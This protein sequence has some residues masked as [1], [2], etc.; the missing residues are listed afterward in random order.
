M[1]FTLMVTSELPILH[2]F[3]LAYVWIQRECLGR[4]EISFLQ[5]FMSDMHPWES[6]PREIV[7]PCLPP[8]LG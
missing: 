2:L 6:I 3:A 4:L 1:Y 8:D 7:T 5:Q